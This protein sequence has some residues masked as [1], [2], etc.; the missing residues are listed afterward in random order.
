MLVPEEQRAR[1]TASRAA[2]SSIGIIPWRNDRRHPCRGTRW[3]NGVSRQRRFLCLLG[4]ARALDPRQLPRCA[5]HRQRPCRRLGGR[6]LDRPTA[7]SPPGH[8]G[9]RG[10]ACRL[11]DDQHRRVPAVCAAWL[12][13]LVGGLTLL[14]C[15]VIPSNLAVI[16]LFSVSGIGSALALLATTLVI[17]RHTP[18]AVRARVF[19][20]SGSVN[21]G[22]LVIA[23][24][25]GG[26]LVGPLG[27]VA[28]CVVCG[29]V[30]TL[31][32]VPSYF[33]PPRGRLPWKPEAERV[34]P[35]ET[36]RSRWLFAT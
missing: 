29:V 7:S 24:I 30:T 22:A 32:L 4:T 17:Q 28:L 2:A 26:A 16:L 14:A 12:G 19:A 1:A 13:W 20:A 21:I 3:D 10:C 31:A 35:S 27:P 11:R 25:V 34:E 15:G 9:E 23:M 6:S 8:R 36:R 33:L 18:D 5:K